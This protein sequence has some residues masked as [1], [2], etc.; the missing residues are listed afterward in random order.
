MRKI[1]LSLTLDTKYKLFLC[2]TICPLTRV[3][4]EVWRLPVTE[5]I[6]EFVKFVAHMKTNMKVWRSILWEIGTKIW[7]ENSSSI[8]KV[9]Q[10]GMLVGWLTG[11]IV[12][13]WSSANPCYPGFESCWGSWPD[14]FFQQ[15][16]CIFIQLV[17]SSHRKRGVPFQNVRRCA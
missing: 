8:F 3:I 1:K 7:D 17:A 9:E 16:T 4:R 10:Q 2:I 12:I 6:T 14:C 15:D 13:G 5:S 11:C